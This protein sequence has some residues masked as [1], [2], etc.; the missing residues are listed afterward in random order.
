MCAALSI[1]VVTELLVPVIRQYE[2]GG[3]KGQK[4]DNELSITAVG[5]VMFK[6]KWVNLWLT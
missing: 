3:G 6:I 5:T 4:A 2:G 1:N